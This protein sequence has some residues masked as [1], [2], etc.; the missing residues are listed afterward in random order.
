MV[1]RVATR[2]RYEG[3]QFWGCST[4]PNC[5][6]VIGVKPDVAEAVLD[7]AVAPSSPAGASAQAEYERA[8]EKNRQRIRRQWPF[9][10]GVTLV[11]TF[12]VYLVVQSITDARWGAAAAAAVAFVLL[13]AFVNSPKMAAWREGAEGERRTARHLDGLADAGF[14]VFHDRRVPGYGGNLDH[15]AIG[16]SGVWAIETK[17]WTGKVEIDGDELLVSGHRRDKAVDQVFREATAV[18]IALGEA[19]M[20]LG[21]TVTPVLCLYRARMPFFAKAAQGVRVVSGKQLVAL[22]RNGENRLTAE[23]VQALAR[24]AERVLRP[25]IR[26][27]GR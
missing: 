20:R 8:R 17:S 10:I 14:I 21:L 24:E 12:V 11:V 23:Q 25:A 16:P 9:A 5:R 1:L 13:G 6:A 3:Q 27:A 2:G 19:A 4:F 15:V 22:L 7:T 26:G 18:Q